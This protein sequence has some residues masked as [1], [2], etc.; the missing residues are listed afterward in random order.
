MTAL[1]ATQNTDHKH[2]L[3]WWVILLQ[4]FLSI[5]IGFF[6]LASPGISVVV[7]IQL[8]GIYWL[9]SG[10]LTLVSIFIDKYLWGWKLF[11]GVIGILAGVYIIQNPILNAVLIPTL[12]VT[13]L[14]IQGII[15]GIVYIFEAIKGLG[16]GTAILGILS[17]LLGILLISS[18]LFAAKWII[19]MLGVF[20]L[21][22]GISAVLYAIF[23]ARKKTEA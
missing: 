9:V 15:Y 16:W 2:E 8:L 12:V 18:P 1:P 4:G 10:V 13:I 23:V 5:I 7:I 3:A 19:L 6:F 14:G 17:I 11:S 20:N 21:V 22:G